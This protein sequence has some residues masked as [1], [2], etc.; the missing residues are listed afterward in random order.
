MLG[1]GCSDPGGAPDGSVDASDATTMDALVVFDLDG[2][3]EAEVAPGCPNVPVVCP[4]A[5]YYL[6][7]NGDGFERIL[8]SN[9]VRDPWGSDARYD[10]PLAEFFPGGEGAPA[11]QV[12][13]TGT[14]DGGG[15]YLTF[16]EWGI[17]YIRADST[18]FTTGWA[19]AAPPTVVYTQGDPPG[20]L[21][22]GSYAGVV[23]GS[24]TTDSGT[25]TLSGTF[26]ACRICDAPATP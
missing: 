20:G 14:P 6:T 3:N 5:D 17:S 21:V 18:G 26:V 22:V 10:V 16:E 15:G 8:R 9:D 19:D 1:N 11:H 4:D 13:A 24:P 23:G 7:V 12:W 2:G 25:L